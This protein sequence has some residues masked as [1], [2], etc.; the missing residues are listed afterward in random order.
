MGY[1]RSEKK[2]PIRDEA[3]I[4][5][6]RRRLETTETLCEAIELEEVIILLED[7]CEFVSVHV[8]DIV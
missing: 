1:L 3:Q 6:R 2:N 8:C 7:E 4:L 5:A